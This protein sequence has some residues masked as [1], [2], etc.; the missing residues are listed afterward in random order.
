MRTFIAAAT[1]ACVLVASKGLAM[2]FRLS[3]HT[4]YATGAIEQ[5]DSA[6]LERLVRDNDLTSNIDKY[7]VRLNSPGGSVLEGMRLGTV[8]RDAQLETFIGRGETCASACALAFLGGTRRFATGT[9]VGRQMDFG[10]ALGFH[11]F[12]WATD[13]VRLENETL[14]TSRIITG[15]ILEYGSQMKGVDL[16]W[17]AQAQNVAPEELLYVR[18]P[19]D[20]AALSITLDEIPKTVPKDWHLNACRRAVREMVPVLDKADWRILVESETIPTIKALR[21]AVVSGRFEPGPLETLIATLSDSDAID[22]ALGEP[23]YLDIRKPI[24]DARRVNI[25]RGAGF[26]YDRCIAVRTKDHVFAILIDLESHRVRLKT[27]DKLAAFDKETP[28]W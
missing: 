18:S 20:I 26:Y 19:A 11:G 17:L 5:G 28:L 14:S 2:G 23:F 24:L 27:F 7:V 9:G 3:D 8:I 6:K 16:G 25:Q 4:I 10:A 1:L 21:A 22:L 15:L 13:T 12:S